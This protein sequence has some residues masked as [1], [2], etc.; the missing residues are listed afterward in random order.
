MTH[1]NCSCCHILACGG[2]FKAVIWSLPPGLH[3]REE[4][5]TIIP[6]PRSQHNPKVRPKKAASPCIP[7]YV[8]NRRF[9]VEKFDNRWPRIAVE[10][11]IVQKK[12]RGSVNNKHTFTRKKRKQD[13]PLK[14]IANYQVVLCCKKRRYK[15]RPFLHIFGRVTVCWALLC[16]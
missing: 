12:F 11:A 13:T 3:V 15:T 10:C 8:K 6:F 5:P 1:L 16:L 4:L 2:L 9:T 14:K 7:T